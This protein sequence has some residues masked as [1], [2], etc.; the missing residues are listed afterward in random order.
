MLLYLCNFRRTSIG[1]GG[2]K[3]HTH[4]PPAEVA[5]K[6]GAFKVVTMTSCCSHETVTPNSG[7]L[8][9]SKHLDLCT[10]T[11][12]PCLIEFMEVVSFDLIS[13]L[14][15]TPREIHCLK[16]WIV[17]VWWESVCRTETLRVCVCVI[18]GPSPWTWEVPRRPSGYR[19]ML[20][21]Q[22]KT[23]LT[24]LS[25]IWACTW[26]VFNAARQTRQKSPGSPTWSVVTLFWCLECVF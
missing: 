14:G 24:H 1:H 25:W 12:G 26:P 17:G 9:S 4:A 6:K 13:L 5:R 8:I 10:R 19:R 16:Q 2:L 20:R 21:I 18:Q 7:L 3:R 22:G 15:V 11:C 23:S